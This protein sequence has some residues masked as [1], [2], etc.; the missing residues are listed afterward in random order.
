MS[1]LKNSRR[2]KFAQACA[3][4]LSAAAAYRS[5]YHYKGKQADSLG[6]RLSVKVSDRIR[7]LKQASATATTLTMKERREIASEIARNK[8]CKPS[9]RLAAVMAEARLAGELTDKVEHSGQVDSTVTTITAE[10]RAERVRAVLIRQGIIPGK[11]ER[12]PA[13]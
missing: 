6:A 13:D 7:E 5:A 12:S 3:S 1:L 4:G 9:D 2:E 11:I 10:Q 8:D